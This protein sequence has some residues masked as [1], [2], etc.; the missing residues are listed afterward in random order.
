MSVLQPCDIATYRD[1][2]KKLV[3]GATVKKE[4]ELICRV[5]GIARAEWGVH[6]AQNPA[7]GRLVPRP[8]KEPGDERNRRLAVV[9]APALPSSQPSGKLSTQGMDTQ[10]SSRRKRADGAF[11]NDPEADALLKMPQSEQQALLRACR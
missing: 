4:L 1:E 7:S 9:H 6:V 8:K 10:G 3:K 2:R 5:I 11:E